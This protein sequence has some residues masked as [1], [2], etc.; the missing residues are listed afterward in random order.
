MN[1]GPAP[2][3]RKENLGMQRTYLD[4]TQKNSIFSNSK[5]SPLW[6]AKYW[7]KIF[8]Y[9]SEEKFSVF[10]VSDC[11]PMSSIE[12]PGPSLVCGAASP[13]SLDM[14]M[15]VSLLVFMLTIIHYYGISTPL[16]QSLCI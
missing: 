8:K 3:V 11:T 7:H 9:F 16:Y 1:L 4:W 13:W 12:P 2:V 14:D 10:G 15:L 5:C 6:K